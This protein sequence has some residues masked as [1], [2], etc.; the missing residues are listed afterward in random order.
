MATD[1]MVRLSNVHKRYD[2]LKV[3]DGVD[4]TVRRSEK[5][6]IIGASGSGKTTLLRCVIGLETIDDGT[7]RIEEEVLQSGKTNESTSGTEKKKNMRRLHGKVGMV[8][9]QFNLF[10]HMTVLEN[11]TEA[12]V[13]VKKIPQKQADAKARKLLAKVGL[14]DKLDVYPSKLSGGQQQRTAIARALAMEPEIMLFD[15]VTSALDPELI[16]EVLNVLRQLA[17][18]GMTML[19]VT[20]EMGFASEVADRVI[21]MDQ[22][23]IV[24]EGPPRILFESPRN[25]RTQIFLRAILEH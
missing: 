21:Y 12:P 11:V 15:E 19:I 3:L 25:E 4:L 24:E 18:E 23:R 14:S 9:Q 7:I 2:D 10:P 22:G 5:L 16:G 17:G 1:V 20:H 6:V 13:W 8:F